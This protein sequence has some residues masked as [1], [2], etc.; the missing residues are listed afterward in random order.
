MSREQ[1]IQAQS[2]L[3]EILAAKEVDRL[4]EVFHENVVDHDPAPGQAA[5]IE[6]IVQFWSG[7]FAAFPD[8]SIDLESLVAD[9]DSVVVT[10]TVTGTHSGPLMG[11]EPTGRRM[12]V[13]G[14][15]VGRFED[16]M[17]VERWGSTDQLGM[18][19]QLGI[20]DLGS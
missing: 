17:L 3:G 16:G 19:Q 1:N 9:D 4:H 11:I 5:G 8:L 6:G 14:I 2:R 18:L 12:S 7:F 20:V 13:R 15:Q 10:L